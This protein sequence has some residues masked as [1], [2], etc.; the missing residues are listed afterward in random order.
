MMKKM[1]LFLSRNQLLFVFLFI[2]SSLGVL[3]AQLPNACV[4][5]IWYN[6]EEYIT[7]VSF[8]TINN[9][10]SYIYSNSYVNYTGI[11]TNVTQGSQYTLSVSIYSEYGDDML[12]AYFDWNGNGVLNDAGEVYQLTGGSGYGNLTYTQNI[13]IPNTSVTGP[14]RMRVIVSYDDYNYNGPCY[15]AL[16]GEVEDYTVNI[17]PSTNCVAPVS[18]GT[19]V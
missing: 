11:S 9:S 16:Y 19:V 2:F 13:I 4:P 17:V 8:N 5:D 12:Y 7:N 18:G 6:D 15:D 10:S 14:I 3:R 1:N